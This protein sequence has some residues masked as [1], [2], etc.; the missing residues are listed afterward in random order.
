MYKF[1]Y[2]FKDGLMTCLNFLSVK[3][4]FGLRSDE[5]SGVI[6]KQTFFAPNRSKMN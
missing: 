5:S 6:S 4:W 1:K 2:M 3:D